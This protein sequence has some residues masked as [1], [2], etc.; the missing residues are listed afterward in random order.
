VSDERSKD[1]EIVSLAGVR[2]RR[3][4]EVHDMPRSRVIRAFMI[5]LA[6]D[7]IFDFLKDATRMECPAC[8]EPDRL[9]Y[10]PPVVLCLSCHA[11]WHEGLDGLHSGR[12]PTATLKDLSEP[13]MK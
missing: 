3:D 2:Q 13:P 4:A 12:F 10:V 9:E 1:G 8:G 11:M 5:G 7:S 6:I